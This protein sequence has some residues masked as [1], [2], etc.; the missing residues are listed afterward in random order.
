MPRVTNETLDEVASMIAEGETVRGVAGRMGRPL[1]TVASWS[2]RPDVKQKV[3]AIK[4]RKASARA[5]ARAAVTVPLSETDAEEFTRHAKTAAR[6]ALS[7]VVKRHNSGDDVP[8]ADWSRL[9][10]VLERFA[11]E[12]DA[13]MTPATIAQ[14]LADAE[15][16][17]QVIDSLDPR[18]ATAMLA[19]LRERSFELLRRER[20]FDAPGVA[21]AFRIC[22]RWAPAEVAGRW[23]ARWRAVMELSKADLARLISRDAHQ[24]VADAHQDDTAGGFAVI[25]DRHPLA[26]IEAVLAAANTTTNETD[27]KD[28]DHGPTP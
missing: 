14:A 23:L 16:A 26:T 21:D 28:T 13:G 27:E 15:L 1:G 22:E 9:V 17:G 2:R 12:D 19:G 18:T 6:I 10:S 24:Q 20:D 7:Q 25:D 3:A 8:L 5:K 11:S 4:A